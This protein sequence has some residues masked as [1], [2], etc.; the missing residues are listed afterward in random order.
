MPPLLAFIEV[1]FRI[2]LPFLQAIV[3]RFHSE[4]HNE[5]L[6][7][8]ALLL[9][10]LITQKS[11]KKALILLIFLRILRSPSCRRFHRRRPSRGISHLHIIKS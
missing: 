4:I 1:L 2:F 11:M 7:V 10:I 5:I 9:E 6:F 8:I 3:L